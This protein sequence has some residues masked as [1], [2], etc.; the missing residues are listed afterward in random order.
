MHSFE[1]EGPAWLEQISPK[2]PGPQEEV[3]VTILHNGDYSG[4]VRV[5][6]PSAVA[7]VATHHYTDVSGQ[8]VHNAEIHVPFEALEAFVLAKWQREMVATIENADKDQLVFLVTLAKAFGK[9]GK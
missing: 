8:D 9:G 3:V 6:V 2:R 4:N 7:N 1:W 5:V